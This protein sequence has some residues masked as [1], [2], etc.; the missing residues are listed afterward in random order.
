[1]SW[2]DRIEA[3]LVIRT[4][5][6]KEFRPNWKDAT[7]VVDFNVSEFNFPN[8][9]GTLVARG[10]PRGT[11][12]DV[13]FFFQGDDHLDI[14]EEFRIAAN[15][16]RPWTLIHP[17][18]GAIVV[19]PLSLTFDN[20]NLNVSEVSGTVV[21]TIT[22]DAPKTSINPVDKIRA[23]SSTTL[24]T[25]ANYFAVD[26]KPGVVEIN[27]MAKVNASVYSEGA[28]RIKLTEN[29]EEY[30]N[31]FNKANAAVL[32][33]TI[34]PLAAITAMQA[35]ITYPALLVDS[36]KNRMSMLQVQFDQLR[37][38]LEN[39]VNPPS[40]R[41][42]ENNAASIITTM[43]VASANPQ[44]GDYANRKEVYAVV[45]QILANNNTYLTDLDA[46]QTNN[47]GTSSSYIPDSDSLYSLNALVNFTISNLFSIALDS[48]QERSI[49]TEEDTNLILLAHRFYGIDETDD[50]LDTLMQNNDIGLNEML[51]VKKGRKILYYV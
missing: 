22:D 17:F 12:Y 50:D 9:D 45:Q 51:A 21:E 27:Q 18:Y 38:Q 26:V 24:T 46:M 14:A 39:I 28:K 44:P 29:A 20:T 23:D 11:K 34:E 40:K 2:I 30:F 1:M 31:L 4:G 42:Y 6:Y 5:N 35:V 7:R 36:I 47:G 32:N 25:F 3:D 15:D 37:V 13:R 41:I 16:P 10:R 48:K 19:Q 43:S 8:L 49:I 33:A